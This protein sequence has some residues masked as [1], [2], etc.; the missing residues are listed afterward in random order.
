M[1][2]LPEFFQGS[3]AHDF[4]AILD[5]DLAR[6]AASD[7]TAPKVKKHAEKP[8]ETPPPGC[9]P[10]KTP[11]VGCTVGQG[12]EPKP[13][14]TPPPKCPPP[15]TPMVGCTNDCPPRPKGKKLATF[16]PVVEGWSLPPDPPAL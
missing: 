8:P 5:A 7:K 10:P 16:V 11:N 3:I 12:C 13:I 15:K 6:E 4:Q 2:T 1:A 14:E 9:P